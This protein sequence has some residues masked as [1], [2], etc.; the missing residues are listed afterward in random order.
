MKFNYLWHLLVWGLPVIALQWAI[1]CRIFAR[2][3]R[4]LLYP[5]LIAGTYYSIVDSFAVRS[6]I[7]FFDPQQI[8]GIHIGPLPLEEVL[9]FYLT[10]LLVAQ[11][12]ILFLPQRF[13]D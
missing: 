12:L 1:G 8:L 2:N 11:S 5:T 6:G 13:R 4:A 10:S 3:W 7:W 9:F